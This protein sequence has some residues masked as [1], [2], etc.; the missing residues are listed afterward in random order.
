MGLRVMSRLE[1]IKR[2]IGVKLPENKPN[3]FTSFKQLSETVRKPL[4][5]FP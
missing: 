3:L 5:I 4:I 2:A 1:V